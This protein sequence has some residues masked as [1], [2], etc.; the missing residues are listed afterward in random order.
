MWFYRTP[1]QK[2]DEKKCQPKNLGMVMQHAVLDSSNWTQSY[3]LRAVRI[4]CYDEHQAIVQCCSMDVFANRA[5]VSSEW[6][7]IDN[8]P[9]DRVWH[10][11]AAGMIFPHRTCWNSS[12]G[13]LEW[14]SCVES[15]QW[16]GLECKYHCDISWN[17]DNI[18]CAKCYQNI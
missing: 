3:F 13:S 8:D 14:L 4:H 10:G 5:A 12:G 7:A 15:G 6:H 2:K 17:N 1:P 9:V 18:L 16:H 11:Y